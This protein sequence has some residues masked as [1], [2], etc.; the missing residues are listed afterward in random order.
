MINLIQITQQKIGSEQINSVN[1]RDVYTHL[2]IKTPYSMWIQRCIEKYDFIDGEDFTINS[3][4]SGKATQNDYIVSLDMAKE[5]CMITDTPKGK[6]VRK[7]FIQAEKQS[8]KVLSISEQI[9]LIAK[10]HQEVHIQ[11]QSQDDRLTIIEQTKRLENWQERALMDAKNTKVYE[12]AKD[13]KPFATKLHRK[14]WSLFK[15]HFHLSRYNELP[16]LK[17]D[18]G[19]EYIR[20]LTI[21]D[22][23]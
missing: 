20:N 10:G 15:R 23:I 11:L 16:S 2:E 18:E 19:V 12:I 13:D 21:G 17:Y 3:F 6:E 22:M 8:T 4:V 7:Y 14:V 9:S 1:S 5:L